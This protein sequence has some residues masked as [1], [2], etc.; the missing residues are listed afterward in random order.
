MIES[1]PDAASPSCT[2]NRH[3]QTARACVVVLALLWA[4]VAANGLRAGSSGRHVATADAPSGTVNPNSAAWYELTLLPRI[5]ESKARALV[6]CR[7]ARMSDG[8]G[9][10]FARPTDLTEARGIGPKTVER[11]AR[12]LRFDD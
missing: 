11:M 8:I 12:E 7:A 5:G 2:N 3:D 6:R 4:V 9:P 10:S 1:S